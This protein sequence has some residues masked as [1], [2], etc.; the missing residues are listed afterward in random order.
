MGDKRAS[1]REIQKSPKAISGRA[2]RHG[3]KD[4]AP[5]PGRSPLRKRREKS[6]EA[7]V[8]KMSAERQMERRAEELRN[9]TNGRTLCTGRGDSKRWRKSI[10]AILRTGWIPR[11]LTMASRSSVC[12]RTD[13]KE[14]DE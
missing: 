7:I 4:C 8:V 5:Y 12:G 3:P 13:A 1:Q 9:I 11:P 2:G 10:D 6:A 14:S